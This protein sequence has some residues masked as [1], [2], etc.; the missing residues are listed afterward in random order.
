MSVDMANLQAGRG[1]ADL[2]SFI[3]PKCTGEFMPK[4]KDQRYCAKACAKAASRNAARGDRIN[5]NQVRNGEHYNR[6]SWL[7]YNLNR[8]SPVRQRAMILAF[9]EA[10]S[11]SNAKLRA[12]LLD[13]RLLGADKVA[14]IGKLYPDTHPS[15]LNVAKMVYAFCQSEWGCNTRDAILDDGKPA[16]RLFKEDCDEEPEP[17]VSEKYRRWNGGRVKTLKG[18]YDWRKIARAMGDRGWRRYYSQTEMDALL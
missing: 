16:H 8:M 2:A 6:A 3:C 17:K 5:E 18:P 11:G 1:R 7:S 10:A 9:L 14:H 15:A 13:P 12:I 4:R